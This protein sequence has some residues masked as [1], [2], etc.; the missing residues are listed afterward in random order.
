MEPAKDP[1]DGK[2]PLTI[3][4]VGC[5]AVGRAFALALAARGARVALWSRRCE[6][7]EAL[8][9][10]LEAAHPGRV[11]AVAMEDLAH[12]DGVLV[13]VHDE[14]ITEVAERLA[15]GGA[16]PVVW[17]T[18]GYY[19]AEILEPLRVAG[20][21]CGKLHPLL[22]FPREPQEAAG[23]DRLHGAVFG[24]AGDER[25]LNLALR[26]V[27]LLEG[28]ALRLKAGAQHDRIYHAAAS[29]VSGGHVALVEAAARCL[30]GALE[31]SS[32]GPGS[33]GD[34]ERTRFALRC[35]E[36]LMRSTEANIHAGLG[37]RAL[38]GPVA[39]GAEELVEGHVQALGA[40]D[41]AAAE[42]YGALLPIM[43]GLAESATR[44]LPDKN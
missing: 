35:L 36:P 14:A 21:A 10:A 26:I 40:K 11:G 8:T 43:R 19:G 41:P 24:L 16:P 15:T 2:A 25:A 6:S 22:S 29:L 27:S 31:P 5:G 12:A 4:I 37:A 34:E 23:E 7:L 18:C 9:G 33:A 42:L 28:Q 44:T 38:T 17:H 30:A 3:G 13:C 32:I 39:R 1:T 20:V